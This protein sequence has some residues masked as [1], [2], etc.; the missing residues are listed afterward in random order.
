MTNPA[1]AIDM[2]QKGGDSFVF[3]ER[4]GAV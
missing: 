2:V 4:I 3:S 1:G